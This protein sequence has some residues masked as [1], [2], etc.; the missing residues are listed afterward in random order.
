MAALPAPTKPPYACHHGK[1]TQDRHYAA[2]NDA[3]QPPFASGENWCLGNLSGTMSSILDNYRGS[4]KSEGLGDGAMPGVH[5]APYAADKSPIAKLALDAAT[6]M[7][8]YFH[9]QENCPHR[10]AASVFSGPAPTGRTGVDGRRVGLRKRAENFC[11]K[12]LVASKSLLYSGLQK[13]V[14]SGSV[15]LKGMF[16]NQTRG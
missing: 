6:R 7:P 1:R 9:R 12:V 11:P 5:V 3:G 8:E 16:F 14:L 10:D 2:K 15:V 13:F 4:V